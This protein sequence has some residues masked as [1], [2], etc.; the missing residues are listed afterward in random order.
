MKIKTKINLYFIAA[1][2]IASIS[3]GYVVD[4]YTSGLVKSYIYSDIQSDNRA[5]AEHVR[6]FVQDKETISVILAAASV[7]RDFLKEPVK[8][9]QY[10]VI[11]QKIDNRLSRTIEADPQ[12]LEAFILDTK[13]KILASSLKTREGL[14]TGTEY[15]PNEN[16]DI[17][18]KDIYFSKTS[19]K[20]GY[21]ISAPVRDDNGILFGVSV[22]RYETGNL[23]EILS[24]IQTADGRDD[25]EESFLI[26]KDTYFI[27]PSL[28]L[29][30]DVILKQKVETKNATDCF[31]PKEIEYVT[32][33]G[34]SGLSEAF[35]SQL[36]EAKDYRGVSVVG[37]HSYI[38]ETGWCLI[39][40]ADASELLSYRM[41]LIFAIVSIF[42]AGLF[43]FLLIGYILSKKITNPIKILQDGTKKIVKGDLDYKV[44][45]SSED[46]IGDLARSFNSMTEAVKESR[47][48]IDRK[49]AE[50]TAALSLKTKQSDDQKR[51]ILNILEDVE[52]EKGKLNEA[53]TR[54][55]IATESARIGVLELDLA[56]NALSMDEITS[57]LYGLKK[58]SMTFSFAEWQSHVH[59]DDLA[60]VVEKVN[61][62]VGGTGYFEDTFRV[63]WPNGTSRY[64]RGYAQVEKDRDN[65]PV[66]LV[67]VNFDVTKEREVDLEKTEFVSL[68]SHQLKTPI[69]ALNWDLEMLLSGD[70]GPLDEK[71]KEVITEMYT[72][73]R[74]MNDLIN[75]LLNISRI[76]MGVFIIEPVPTD[77]GSVC[78]EV[79]REMASR[80]KEKKHHVTKKYAKEVKSIPADPKLLRIIFQNYI[81]NSVKYTQ[82]KGEIAI[83]IGVTDT[84]VVITVANNGAPIPEKDKS[85][86]FS[87]LFRASNAQDM[88]PDGTG[89]GLY[90]VREI[91][92]HGGG[93]AWFESEATGTAFHIS[94]PL[95]GMIKKEGT[96]A[97]S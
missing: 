57:E 91:A 69:G 44:D 55:K 97:L 49:V 71:K 45:I 62:A 38:P 12:V 26:N 8:S 64:I 9:S 50:Q 21:T 41:P 96:K 17:Y 18:F 61:A 36:V 42:I 37:T 47:A 86:I 43:L 1:F 48:D 85:K 59:P 19:Q 32:K 6:T 31:D 16:A 24:N 79:L 39:T 13:G 80:I 81:S 34:Y 74:R 54:L 51:A 22:L 75:S 83:D 77:F 72:M 68:A 63:L 82:D 84:D 3:I 25:S 87:K 30:A 76:D 73:N 15:F 56:S 88:D 35:G 7:Y 33:N 93:K 95:S 46:E 28:F 94:F 65:K 11:K 29:G 60:R 4:I 14:E 10:K 5:R 58:E 70:Y 78:D 40:K 92:E 90:V 2:I 66:K 67:G 52:S 20:L 23:Y 89:L 27:S 53:T